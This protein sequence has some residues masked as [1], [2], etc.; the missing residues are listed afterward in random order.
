M[1]FAAPAEHKRLILE[2]D[3]SRLYSTVYFSSVSSPFTVTSLGLL[4]LVKVKVGVSIR[5]ERGI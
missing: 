5:L 2:V 3:G 4:G 1:I